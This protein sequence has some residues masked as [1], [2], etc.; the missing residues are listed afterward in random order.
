MPD[1]WKISWSLAMRHWKV[2]RRDLLAN[3]SP[4]IIEPIL[5]VLTFGLGLG[6]YVNEVEGRE[7]LKYIAPGLVASSALFTA[8]F[9]SSYGFFVRL[10]FEFIFD[11]ILT[12]PA[13]ALEIIAGE[14]IWVCI[15]GAVMGS[16]VTGMLL[17]FGL[18]EVDY[19]YAVP[20]V[21]AL[22]ALACGAIGLMATALCKNINQFQ[23]IY[24]FL[25]AP[26]FFFSGIFY[27]LN[28]EILWIKVLAYISP[29]F[30]G[31]KLS[32]YLLWA[33]LDAF[34]I[35]F[36]GGCLFLLAAIFIVISERMMRPK[37]LS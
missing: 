26:M 25:I 9:E 1:F 10:K 31:A 12:S 11:A 6:A 4:T 28:T 3:S 20:L 27:P 5:F 23:T 36:H 15:K 7:Y 37:L 18:I 14:F 2:Y 30:H 34:E 29:V 16:M 21:A 17:L 19:V 33:E 35:A 13:S 32:Q 24:A 22:V 8:F